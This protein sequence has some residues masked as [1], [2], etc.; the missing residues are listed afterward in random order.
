[1]VQIILS[2]CT[3]LL[4]QIMVVELEFKRIDENFCKLWR[5]IF[6]GLFDFSLFLT[7]W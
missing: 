5:I 3:V 7:L 2:G 1:M 6:M 4:Y